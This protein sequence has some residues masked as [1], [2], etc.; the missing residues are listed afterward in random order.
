[1]PLEFPNC[2][3]AQRRLSHWST[4]LWSAAFTDLLHSLRTTKRT[5]YSGIPNF[6]WSQIGW[7]HT[8]F[9]TYGAQLAILNFL[10]AKQTKNE[11]WKPPDRY[12]F[13]L[14]DGLEQGS[15]AEEAQL[16]C[17]RA[18]P[19]AIYGPWPAIQQMLALKEQQLE[20]CHALQICSTRGWLLNLLA[21][22]PTL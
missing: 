7:T 10:M 22:I 20:R 6:H 16:P 4:T 5:K 13:I 14:L 12:Y 17:W 3:T 18:A 21:P 15:S 19:L 9:S 2:G 11:S 1:M 8:I